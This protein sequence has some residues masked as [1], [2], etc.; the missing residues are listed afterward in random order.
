MACNDCPNCHMQSEFIGGVSNKSWSLQLF[1]S[2]P[3]TSSSD[4]TKYLNA[5]N[6]NVQKVSLLST[7]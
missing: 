1:M 5:M 6:L 7:F 3:E 4:T 2:S